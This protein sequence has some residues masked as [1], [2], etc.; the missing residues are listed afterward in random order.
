MLVH[1]ERGGVS[2]LLPMEVPCMWLTPVGV[3]ADRTG[4]VPLT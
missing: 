2:Y 3:A 4:S 1:F